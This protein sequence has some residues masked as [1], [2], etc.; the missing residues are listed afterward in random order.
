MCAILRNSDLIE[1]N[2][3]SKVNL[4]RKSEFKHIES[5]YINL[6]SDLNNQSI[7]NL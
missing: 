4:N 1:S 5:I 6:K 2:V 3:N 7:L